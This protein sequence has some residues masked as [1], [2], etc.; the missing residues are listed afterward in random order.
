M[1]KV[2]DTGRED[3]SKFDNIDSDILEAYLRADLNASDGKRMEPDAIFYIIELL[4]KRQKDNQTDWQQK[5]SASWA[6]FSGD[7]YPYI[8]EASN[9]YDFYNDFGDDRTDTKSDN[10]K[11]FILHKLGKYWRRF[12]SVA[13]IMVLFMFVGTV[14][15]YALGYNPFGI[16]GK[17][18][19][20]VFWLE[21][22]CVTSELADKMAEYAG[23]LEMVPKWLPDGYV[24]DTIELLEP[25]DGVFNNIHAVFY[26]NTENGVD[27]LYIDYRFPLIE[28]ENPLYEKDT[29]DAEKYGMYG[30]KYY[31]INNIDT[32]T[33]IWRNASFGGSIKGQFSVDEAKKIVNSI[34]GE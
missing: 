2:E 25:D 18:N 17:W 26:Q 31:I 3:Y 30:T 9:M 4:S 21:T 33:I 6:E 34:Y 11:I 27:K 8:E 32:T 22:D 13:A 14:G 1:S 29:I 16:I 28:E 24:F 12:A 15:A 23:D 19:E 10:S 5:T 20:E 7:Y